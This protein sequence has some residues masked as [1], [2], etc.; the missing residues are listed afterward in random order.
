MVTTGAMTNRVDRLEQRGLV[1]RSTVP[2]DRRKM[3][4]R[5]TPSGLE[6]VDEVVQGH[7]DTERELLRS[8]SSSQQASLARLLRTALIGLDD[9]PPARPT[10]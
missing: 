4:V 2:G 9:R 8:L 3:L 1:E 5:L 6:L 10:S 7:L